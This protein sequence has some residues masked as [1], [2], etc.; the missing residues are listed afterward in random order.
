MIIKQRQ[1]ILDQDP[2]VTG[3]NVGINVGA[4]AGQ[5]VFH[6]HVHLIPRRDYDVV[7]P[8][9]TAAVWDSSRSTFNSASSSEY[10]LKISEFEP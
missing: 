10:V 6:V 7:D 1:S 8:C 9:Y 4:S 3:F 2:T 5:A